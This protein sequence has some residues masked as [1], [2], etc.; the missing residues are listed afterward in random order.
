MTHLEILEFSRQ[1]KKAML[2]LH[3]AAN[4]YAAARCLLISGLFPGLSIGAQAIEKFLKAITLLAS[5]ST[6][7]GWTHNLPN[8]LANVEQHVPAIYALDCAPVAQRFHEYYQTRY[9]DNPGQP[10]SMNTAE[11][12]ELDRTIVG[13]NLILPCPRNVRMRSGLF[14]AVTFS[15]NHL[16]NVTPTERWIK[17]RNLALDLHWSAIERD[18][19]DAMREIYPQTS[20]LHSSQ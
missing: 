15:L 19:F 4:D 16:N 9:P 6:K 13:L 5:P 17:Q 14:A 3:T 20:E 2:L 18:Y 7:V 12:D 8:L 10:S 1:N 11:I